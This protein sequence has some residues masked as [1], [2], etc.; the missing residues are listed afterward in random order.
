[1]NFLFIYF[2]FVRTSYLSTNSIFFKKKK[3]KNGSFIG[4]LIPPIFY[5]LKVSWWD[6]YAP[7]HTFEATIDIYMSQTL[8]LFYNM[9]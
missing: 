2:K 8:K 1:M 4:Y 5:I 9:P 7:L 6:N 3:E